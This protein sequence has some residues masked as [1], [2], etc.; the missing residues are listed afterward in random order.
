M[1]KMIFAAALMMV[2]TGLKA[3]DCD[4][5]VLPW[6][7]NDRVAMEMLQGVVSDFPSVAIPKGEIPERCCVWI[8]RRADG[9]E[10]HIFMVS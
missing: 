6:F 2:A 10:H 1:K 8:A 7:G 4:A 3:Q 5:L 9:V